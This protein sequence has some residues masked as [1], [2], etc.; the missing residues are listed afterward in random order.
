MAP[1]A[2][3]VAMSVVSVV[4]P[5]RNEAE[6]IGQ[7][8]DGITQAFRRNNWD[9]EI[10][11]V[12]DASTDSTEDVVNRI[13]ER[14]PNVRVI[15]NKEP[16]G[17]GNAIKR[18][19]DY[20]TGDYVII[21][22]AD[23]SDSPDAMVEYVRSMQQGYDCCFGSRWGGGAHVEGYPWL[24][25]ALNRM[26]NGFIQIL[27]GLRYNDITNA[28]KGYSRETIEGIKP[29]LSHHFNITVELPLKAIVRGYNYRVIPTDWH[30]RRKGKTN[31]KIQEMGSRY[32][33]IILYVLLEKWLSRGDYK[34]HG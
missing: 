17:F 4:I 3:G 20:F 30:E 11:I 16:Y 33:F 22:M 8:I 2:R 13:H 14:D 24:K 9:Y 29:V 7:T 21:T 6:N 25:L 10:I 34:R 23:S 15:R 27:F 28:F 12:N 5:A 31:L 26:A 19:L 1:S 32:L 18:G